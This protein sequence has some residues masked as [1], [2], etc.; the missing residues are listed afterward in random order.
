M[1]ESDR[2]RLRAKSEADAARASEAL[3]AAKRRK[4]ELQAMVRAIQAKAAD[5]RQQAESVVEQLRQRGW[6]EYL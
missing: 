2:V 3:A 4:L 5:E 1:S 6:E